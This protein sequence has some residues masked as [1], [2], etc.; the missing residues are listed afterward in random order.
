MLTHYQILDISEDATASEIKAAY[1]RQALKFHPDRNQGDP[2]ME[3]LFKELNAAHQV[4]SNPYTR[5]RYDMTLKY[6]SFELPPKPTSPPPPHY[7][8]RPRDPIFK[9]PSLTS[10][11][12][13]KGTLYAFLFAFVVG[14]LIKI[15]IWA[16]EYYKAVEK[17]K[18][19]TERRYTFA[20]A[21]NAYKNG[22]LKESL[23]MIDGMGMF[24]ESE[25]DMSEYKDMLLSNILIRANKCMEEK[26]YSRAIALYN[27]LNDFPIGNT[28]NIM[29]NKAEAN[30]Q[31]QNYQ[32]AI[33][34]YQQLYMAGYNTTSFYVEMGDLYEMGFKDFESALNY[35]QQA[36]NMATAEY[37]ANYGKAYPILIN[38]EM[39]P[40]YHFELFMKLANAY[41]MT[42]N[43][44]KSLKSTEWTKEI[45]PDSTMNYIISGKC[46]LA[47]N[48]ENFACAD[49]KIARKL[50]PVFDSPLVCAK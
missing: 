10:K 25:R 30:K 16:T 50:D 13:L 4:L 21:Q 34:I 31:L 27:I 28:L 6:G 22:E 5:Y 46:H 32:Q 18:M 20:N 45:W 3:E 19:L 24:F 29:L 11:E 15:G 26:R 8:R 33:Q 42:G 47:M 1:K 41:Y 40:K 17:E 12:N 9:R 39:I 44:E 14:V 2:V 23:L 37:E 49:F 35:Y 48:K 38:A 36:S 7:Y 43:Y